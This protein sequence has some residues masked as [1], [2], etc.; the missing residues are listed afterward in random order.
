MPS[1]P[2]TVRNSKV[3]SLVSRH[4]QRWDQIAFA[5][6]FLEIIAAAGEGQPSGVRAFLKMSEKSLFAAQLISNPQTD[7][8]PNTNGETNDQN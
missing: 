1:V 7:T 6:T 5:I 2:A 4:L 3:G 8:L